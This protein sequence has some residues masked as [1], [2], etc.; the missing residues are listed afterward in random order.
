M[1]ASQPVV[2]DVVQ[3]VHIVNQHRLRGVEQRRRLLQRA[4]RLQQPVALVADAHVDAVAV[5]SRYVLFNL[6]CQMMHVHHQSPVALAAQSR[7][8][9]VQ[10]RLPAHADQRLRRV[11]G[12]RLQSGAH[13]GSKNHGLFHLDCRFP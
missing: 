11:V 10:Q 9:P 5:L 3:D 8:Q 4:T 13:A 1:L 6:V 7:R 2:V 12:Q